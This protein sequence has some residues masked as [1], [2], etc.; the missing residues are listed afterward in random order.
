M[1]DDEDD[2]G[3]SEGQLDDKREAVKRYEEMLREKKD[4]FFD[5]DTLNFIIDHYFEIGQYSQALEVS[6]YAIKLHPSQFELMLRQATLLAKTGNEKAALEALNRYEAINPV[7]PD[8]YLLRANI[9]CSINEFLNAIENF[10]TAIKFNDDPAPIYH[11]L[12]FAYA[13]AGDYDNAIRYMKKYLQSGWQDTLAYDQLIN[14]LSILQL[15]ESELPFFQAQIDNDPYSDSA[16]L[17][18]AMVCKE[19]KYYDKALHAL[20]YCL[21]I[22]SENI[23]AYLEQGDVYFLLE[24]Y[25]DAIKSYQNSLEFFPG[26]AITYYN[27][28]ECYERLNDFETAR[29]NY[30]RAIRL[31]PDLSAA[32]YSLGMVLNYQ[33]KFYEAIHYLKKS[34]ELEPGNAEFWFALA[35][36]ES[37]LNHFNE[38]IAC[39]ENVVD[40]EPDNEDIYVEYSLFLFENNQLQDAL[41]TIATGIKILPGNAELYYY[42][43]CYLYTDG[44]LQAAYEELITGL[45]KDNTLYPLIFDIIPGLNNDDKILEIIKS[46]TS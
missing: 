32:W 23:Q 14:W 21:L 15:L 3:L 22:T 40:L 30:G 33:E 45:T 8:L 27:I 5:V 35:D 28:G 38:A 41:E 10:H 1:F 46:Y 43:A 25:T 2:F 19:L 34:V 29:E 20:D 37:S 13:D 4:Y 9:Y 24:R 36:C 31:Y 6:N 16:W 7:S 11:D 39:Y 44:K 42:N 26:N 18:M 12:S 17:A